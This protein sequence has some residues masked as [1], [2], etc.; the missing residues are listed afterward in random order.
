[1][2]DEPGDE[3]GF[4]RRQSQS[5]AN[6]AGNPGAGD[7]MIFRAALGDVVQKRSDVQNTAVLD[8]FDEFVG[9]WMHFP[10]LAAI[11]LGHDT[12]RSDQML[13]DRIMMIHIELHHRHDHAKF[14][15]ETAQNPRLVHPPQRGFGISRRR[16]QSQ[17][18]AIGLRIAAQFIV[19]QPD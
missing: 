14:W 10:C 9:E 15:H 7:R 2:L 19:D 18:N 16:Q 8:R 17:K 6:L 4:R 5:R 13:I 1:M 3:L 12:H 11:D